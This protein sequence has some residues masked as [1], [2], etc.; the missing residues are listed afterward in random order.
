M[1]GPVQLTGL[2]GFVNSNPE[3]TPSEIQGYSA[4]PAHA[5][6]LW[7]QPEIYPWESGI[8]GLTASADPIPIFTDSIGDIPPEMPAGQLGQ[9]PVADITPR[10]H[11]APWPKGL[12]G[13]RKGNQQPEGTTEY[14]VDSSDIHASDTNAGAGM[15]YDPTLFAKQDDWD[16]FFEVQ[17]GESMLDPNIGSQGRSG[18][19]P[20]GWGSHGREQSNARQN[21]YGFDS[22]HKHRRYAR[23]SIPGAYMWMKP[24]GRP[25]VK[26]LPGPARP[27]VGPLSPFA[28][29]NVGW[30]FQASSN[31]GGVL[32]QPA[33]E[34]Q[35]PP[36]PY[37]AAPV[38][39]NSATDEAPIVEFW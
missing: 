27:A 33:G 38:T 29:Q 9:N 11:A 17:P 14:L 35:Q 23:G 37:V 26:S 8:D 28:G 24:G 13:I 30:G 22:A 6:N 21:L 5:Q 34:Y 3:A 12:D 31:V 39:A 2:Q 19:A 7:E 25:M 20:G 10:T 16:A 15:L 1:P 36:T 4:N 32:T 18:M